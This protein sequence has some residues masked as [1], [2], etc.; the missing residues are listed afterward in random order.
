MSD[1]ETEELRALI[2]RER[3]EKKG[4]FPKALRER[5]NGFLRSK[6]RAGVPLK[7]V[8]QELGLSSHTVDYWRARW[9]ERDKDEAKLRRVEVVKEKPLAR[10][11]SRVT[12][13]GPAG[14]RIEDLNLDDAAALWSK[15]S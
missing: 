13:H 12:M 11:K 6:W 4:P 5:F 7:R 14:T 15:L 1:Q 8:G 10:A 9:G 3:G 2:L